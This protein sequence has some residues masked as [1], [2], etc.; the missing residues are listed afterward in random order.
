MHYKKISA[1]A[2]SVAVLTLLGSSNSFAGEGV[3]ESVCRY[4]HV[5]QQDI[6]YLDIKIVHP[7][8]ASRDWRDPITLD[9]TLN[10]TW[11]ESYDPYVT[12]A[13]SAEQE[14]RNT[15]LLTKSF[16]E[17]DEYVNASKEKVRYYQAYTESCKELFLR[18]PVDHPPFSRQLNALDDRQDGS[19]D[20][21]YLQSHLNFVIDNDWDR[22]NG[23]AGKPVV[24]IP[25]KE[26]G[27]PLLSEDYQRKALATPFAWFTLK[28]TSRDPFVID[29]VMYS[30]IQILA[31]DKDGN[32]WRMPWDPDRLA[33]GNPFA[34]E[35]VRK[36]HYDAIK[37]GRLKNGMYPEEVALVTG[38]PDL[39]RYYPVYRNS[40]GHGRYTIDESYRRDGFMKSRRS[41]PDLESKEVARE[42]G[43][44][45]LDVMG[46][47]TYLHFNEEGVLD[48]SDQP[49]GAERWLRHKWFEGS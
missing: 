40:N 5:P 28:G 11:V 49:A 27:V 9:G 34:S 14:W 30:S 15:R 12:Y 25:D 19:L 32:I 8:S 35:K 37:D 22:L 29:E 36:Q 41:L 7:D 46:D 16:I 33:L 24:V 17:R 31:E 23:H 47:D 10:P 26:G 48:F 18:V 6:D 43:W 21:S 1:K 38:R 20:F 44:F 13:E 2:L 39:E 42:M 4:D 45:F 3:I